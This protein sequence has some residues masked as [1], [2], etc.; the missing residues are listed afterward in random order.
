[1][2]APQYSGPADSRSIV[3][4]MPAW[5]QGFKTDNRYFSYLVALIVAAALSCSCK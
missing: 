1:M 5:R 2:D 4:P 3:L